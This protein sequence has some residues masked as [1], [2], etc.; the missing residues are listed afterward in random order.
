MEVLT[1]HGASLVKAR[2]KAYAPELLP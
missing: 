2:L 1:R